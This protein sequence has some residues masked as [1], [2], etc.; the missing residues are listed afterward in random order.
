[1]PNPTQ[2]ELNA[3]LRTC[4]SLWIWLEIFGVES[5]RPEILKLASS[6]GRA[7]ARWLCASL[8]ALNAELFNRYNSNYKQDVFQTHWRLFV[9][10]IE[11]VGNVELAYNNK[12]TRQ[13][14]DEKVSP[15]THSC[16]IKQNEVPTPFPPLPSPSPYL[17]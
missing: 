10:T 9:P 8:S 14:G 3:H 13:R 16:G 6:S 12:K 17:T 5:T 15:N 7:K 2:F 1:M 11:I 4:W